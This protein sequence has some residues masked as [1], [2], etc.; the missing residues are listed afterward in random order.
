MMEPLGNGQ[1]VAVIGG[2]PGGMACA[3]ALRREA[4]RAGRDIEVLLF[5]TKRF[6]VDHNQCA[7]VLSPPLCDILRD[8]FEIALPKALIQREILGYVIHDE[9]EKVA[10]DGEEHGGSSLA[11]RR[12]EFDAYLAQ[13]AQERGVSVIHTRVT[14][15]EFHSD[16]V[17]IFTWRGTYHA[18]AIV[19]AFGI[20]H[21]ISAALA[22][23]TAYRPPPLLDAVITKIHPPWPMPGPISDLLENYIHVILPP[24][25]RVEFGAVI[26]KG[27]HITVIAAGH[28][29]GTT[30]MKALL[31]L[32]AIRRLLPD[33]AQPEGYY[34]GHFP[35]G[36][37]KGMVG[38]R[39]VTIGDA[40]GLVRPFKG[41]GIN[42]AIITGVLAARTLLE[43]GISAEALETFRH[44]CRD[45]TGDI[46]YGTFMRRLAW[47]TSHHLSVAP[48]LRHAAGDPTLREL[49]FDCVS[50]R[51]MFRH[52]VLR[53]GNLSLAM[54]LG[55]AA[56][57]ERVKH[58]SPR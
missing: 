4:A 35:V 24:L 52:I 13:C 44:G 57:V 14:D 53:K 45:I 55:L 34:K 33:D 46:L 9:H 29:V 25:Q 26:P 22:R 20:S 56:V 1:T 17:L 58:G 6:G 40:A 8:E 43:Q 31:A 18:D 39:Y 3:M 19:G 5:E 36:L 10:L 49:L 21:A 54:K 37:A 12:A 28:G 47:F 11:V 7:G 16:G 48:I 32:P 30:D 51:E 15:F 27:D 42:S 38:D 41:K 2:G 50:G 23:Q